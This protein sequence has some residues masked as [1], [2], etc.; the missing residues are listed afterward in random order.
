M[1]SARKF[2][3]PPL[4]T[5]G[6]FTI[7]YLY[8]F[9]MLLN[10][11]EVGQSTRSYY[12]LV[13]LLIMAATVVVALAFGDWP[14][15]KRIMRE[16]L[17]LLAFLGLALFSCLWST[18]P[19]QTVAYGMELV[20][21]AACGLAASTQLDMNRHL[22]VLTAALLIISISSV[23]VCLL[24]PSIGVMHE[25][26]PGAWRG[27][28]PHKNKLG[29]IMSFGILC[30]L[31]G[32]LRG[33]HLMASVTLTVLSLVLVLMSRSKTALLLALC[34]CPVV[35]L[36][37]LL[38]R[39]PHA[40]RVFLGLLVVVA[41]IAIL[42]ELNRGTVLSGMHDVAKAGATMIGKSLALTGRDVIWR[43]CTDLAW[44]RPLLGYGYEGFWGQY[45]PS[46]WI[47][48][49]IGGPQVRADNS[50][51][52]LWLELGLAGVVLFGLMLAEFCRRGFRHLL[53]VSEWVAIWPLICFLFIVICAITEQIFITTPEQAWFVII[54]WGCNLC[55]PCQTDLSDA[56]T[57][58][59]KI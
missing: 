15:F 16:N 2:G 21:P 3:F 50:Y 43:A 24:I 6:L 30:G 26:F 13:V 38:Q 22:R 7:A 55:V 12:K 8:F 57:N 10:E 31:F 40:F 48:E 44:E 49:V 18:M 4:L 45:G 53:K 17:V 14:G 5:D 11:A 25:H 34:L 32:V 20:L 1:T 23:V 36:L 37:R 56:R 19:D 29:R 28:F 9:G 35:L 33:R 46:G 39:R 52:E 27:V 42:W 59:C 41:G 54:I 51:I 58:E 47:R